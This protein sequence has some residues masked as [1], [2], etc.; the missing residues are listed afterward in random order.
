MDKLVRIISMIMN[1]DILWTIIGLC[2]IFWPDLF[3]QEA[4]LYEKDLVKIFP[5][6]KGINN[7][8]YGYGFLWFMSTYLPMMVIS[9]WLTKWFPIKHGLNALVGVSLAHFA[10]FQGLFAFIKGV[11]PTGRFLRYVYNDSVQIRRIGK[12]QVYIALGTEVVAM[13]AFAMSLFNGQ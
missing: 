10:G 5:C 6:H 9:Y 8:F 1:N 2:V 13:L 11:Y 12:L 4:G 7:Q 3:F